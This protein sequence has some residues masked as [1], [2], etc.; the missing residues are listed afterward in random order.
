M[1]PLGTLCPELIDKVF[2]NED[3][4]PFIGS[5]FING[6]QVNC[7]TGDGKVDGHLPGESRERFGIFDPE[8]GRGEYW[9]DGKLNGTPAVVFMSHFY[10]EIWDHGRFVW[11]GQFIPDQ[12]KL[13]MGSSPQ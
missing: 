3:G 5:T 6:I 13:S 8:A 7:F 1:A 4:S 10:V 12:G 2:L 9:T 11:A